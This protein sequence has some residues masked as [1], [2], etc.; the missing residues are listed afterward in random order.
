MSSL[1]IIFLIALS[2]QL[3]YMVIYAMA[4]GWY[5]S[6][7]P[8]E[9][10]V[11]PVSVIVCAFNELENLKILIPK[12]LSQN[13]NCYEVIIVNDQSSDKTYE[14]LIEL[15]TQHSNLK[16]VQIEETPDHFSRKKYGITLGIKAAS[17]DTLVFTDAD[18]YPKTD[19]W[20]RSLTAQYKE[21]TKIVLGVSLY[22]KRSGFL[23]Q[24]IRF[25]TYWTAIQYLG[26]A[27]VG[28]PYMGVG[29]NLSYH[30]SFFFE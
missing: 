13:H 28:S 29:R 24:F 11:L 7:T 19:N 8:T 21:G 9:E 1:I 3:L 12:L 18:C 22:E 30:K 10:K 4:F 27:I 15:R 17:Y 23:N 26:C 16:L 5:R 2:V 6:I 14:Y 25:E 20:L